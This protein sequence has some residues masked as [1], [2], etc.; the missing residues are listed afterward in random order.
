MFQADGEVHAGTPPADGGDRRLRRLA[1]A[2]GGFT[3]VGGAISLLG[4]FTGIYRLTDWAG[5]GISMKANA[6][7]AAAAAGAGLVLLAARP[8]SWVAVRSLGAIVAL[9]GGLTF[10]EHLG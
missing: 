6:A 10:A 7:L 2:L 4:W 5:V 9:I 3:A 8:R 1:M